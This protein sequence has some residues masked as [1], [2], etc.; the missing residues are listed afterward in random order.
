M[1]R[2]PLP[3]VDI[4]IEIGGKI[5]IIERKNTPLGWALPG[6]FVDYGETVETAAARE[7][8]EETSLSLSHLE[9]FHVFSGPQRDPR[10][11]TISTVFIARGHGTASAGDDAKGIRLIN[12]ESYRENI[13]FDHR[14]IISAYLEKKKKTIPPN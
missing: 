4:I 1:P 6:G 13:V 12:P 7:A 9:Q 2:N 10:G 14:A 5:V 8:L 11:H 3:T